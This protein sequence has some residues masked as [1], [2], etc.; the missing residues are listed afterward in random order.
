MTPKNRL[1]T[2][3]VATLRS[4][5][6]D[7]DM[8]ILR[9]I[10]VHRFLTTRQIQR[11]SFWGHAT[12]SAAIRSCVR[13]L[14]RLESRALIFKLNRQIG[15][16]HAGSGSYVWG[17]D[18]A[19]DRL[20]RADAGIAS[21]KRQRAIDPSQM[22]LTH[23]LAIA[24]ARVILEEAARDDL[25]EL[26]AVT[27]EPSNWRTFQG[28]SSVVHMLK[29]DLHAITATGEFEDH[30]FIEI[31]NGTESLPTVL[32]KCVVY[33][34]YFETGREQAATGVFPKVV[35]VMADAR[36]R[37]RIADA[38]EVDRRLEARL[39]CAVA[40]DQFVD[41]V[42]GKVTP[43]SARV[44][45]IPQH[46]TSGLDGATELSSGGQLESEPLAAPKLASNGREVT[47]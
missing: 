12:A 46:Q 8:E 19:G 16:I 14:T 26:L 37:T 30:W 33:Q 25:I 21:T 17:L 32:N 1:G 9:L 45:T 29:P 44:K 36:R 47:P 38:V 23:T 11:L 24:E 41:L 34:R 7:R 5:V 4:I 22:F 42:R 31:D 28:R 2:L 18:D 6:T 35:W 15:G 3:S 27:T 40:P 20:M 39:F 43:V 13:V 10:R